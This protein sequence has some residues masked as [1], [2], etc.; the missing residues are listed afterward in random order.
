MIHG[1]SQIKRLQ[2]QIFHRE[3]SGRS[4]A[5]S[6]STHTPPVQLP[7]W[8]KVMGPGSGHGKHRPTCHLRFL[9][10]SP[11]HHGL[12]STRLRQKGSCTCC[13]ASPGSSRLQ[14]AFPGL[15]GRLQTENLWHL[16]GFVVRTKWSHWRCISTRI[17]R[18]ASRCEHR[19]LRRHLHKQVKEKGH[20]VTRL[21]L[22]VPDEEVGQL[23]ISCL[24]LPKATMLLRNLDG[25]L[26]KP[27][28][29]V[30][31]V[32]K[33]KCSVQEGSENTQCCVFLDISPWKRET[34]I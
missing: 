22:Q 9:K 3:V 23:S 16:R 27:L 12:K 32:I 34:E 25:I 31:L 1:Y 17:L 13:P 5:P 2:G 6:Q 26:S 20:Q 33:M 4:H 10:R 8:E 7:G 18:W 29:L 11:S 15:S 24:L 28:L 19:S 14:L 21:P 30:A